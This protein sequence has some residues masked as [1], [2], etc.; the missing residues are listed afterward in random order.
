MFDTYRVLTPADAQEIVL[1]LEGLSW[2][3]GKARTTEATGTIK[4]N[5]EIKV[6]THKEGKALCT[7]VA[8]AIMAHPRLTTD[9]TVRRLMPPKFNR[10]AGGGE[11]QRHGDAAVMGHIRTDISMTL[12]LSHPKTYTGGELCIEAYD[13]G[14]HQVKGDPGTAIV[15]PTG[16]PH[17]VNPV[18]EGERISVV[19]WFESCY[20]DFHQ[21]QIMRRFLRALR[22][23]EA[24]EALRYGK[25]H[26]SLSCVHSELQRMWIN[27]EFPVRADQVLQVN[28]EPRNAAGDYPQAAG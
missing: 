19:T 5:D 14:F 17:W 22:E 10:Y 18:T 6:S 24:D 7:R 25:V 21:R 2:E 23:M 12:F 16:M 13:G 8:K 27:H 26:T 28:Q 20:R 1:A 4:R 3:Q 11:Y 9:H 15:Y